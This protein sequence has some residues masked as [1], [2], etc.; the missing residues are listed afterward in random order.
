MQDRPQWHDDY[1]TM[2]APQLVQELE[3]IARFPDEYDELHERKTFIAGALA[4]GRNDS[5]IIVLE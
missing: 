5:T 1:I 2:S 4:H 3:R